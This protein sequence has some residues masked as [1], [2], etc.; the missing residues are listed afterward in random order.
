MKIKLTGAGY[1]GYTGHFGVV[2][3]VDGVS[4]EDVSDIEAQRLASIVPIETLEGRNP[5]PAQVILDTYSQPLEHATLQ[6]SQESGVSDAPAVGYTAE[7][8]AAIADKGGI[9]ALRAIGEPLGLRGNSITD[10]MGKILAAAG[11][12]TQAP[13]PV[14]EPVADAPVADAGDQE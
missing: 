7:E 9:K 13:A 5:S 2:E 1:E 3:F 8:L 11:K 10:L 6:T 14:V 4:V 12:G